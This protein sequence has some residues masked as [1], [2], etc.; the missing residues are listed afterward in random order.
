MKTLFALLLLLDGRP[1]MT[2]QE[3][4]DLR[5]MD[6]RTAQ[7]KV[8]DGSLGIPVWKDCNQWFAHVE[9]V[10]NWI[11]EQRAQATAHLEKIRA[12]L[13]SR[14]L[15]PS[16]KANLP[17]ASPVPA[18]AQAFGVY[19]NTADI[20]ALLGYKRRYVT[21]VITKHPDF[22]R[23]RQNM[24]QKNRRWLRQ[25]LEVWIASTDKNLR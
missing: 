25:D 1:C 15:L 6:F 3:I 14:A 9:D 22:P 7:N 17:D 20:A 11:D 24:S 16:R 8:Y 5:G 18:P 13:G 12:Q 2:L 23:P 21:D 10:S 19:L 4:A